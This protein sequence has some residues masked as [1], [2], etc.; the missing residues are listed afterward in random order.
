M[1]CYVLSLGQL[2]KKELLKSFSVFCDSSENPWL[3][4]VALDSKI[5]GG[6]FCLIHHCSLR[7]AHSN[8]SINEKNNLEKNI[9]CFGRGEPGKLPSMGSHRVRHN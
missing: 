1:V 7:P 2:R 8:D 3:R 4:N 9:K 6:Y 5:Q